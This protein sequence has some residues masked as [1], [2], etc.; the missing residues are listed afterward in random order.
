MRLGLLLIAFTGL[1]AAC[2]GTASEP[3]TELSKVARIE[4]DKPTLVF[5]YTDG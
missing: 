4:S 2:G 1:A 5:V 3:G